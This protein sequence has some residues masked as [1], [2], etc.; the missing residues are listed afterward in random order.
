MLAPSVAIQR[1]LGGRG[2]GRFADL[3]LG[4]VWAC[5][6]WS[7]AGRP[8]LLCSGLSGAWLRASSPLVP[9][10]SDQS[11]AAHMLLMPYACGWAGLGGALRNPQK[12]EDCGPQV[13]MCANSLCPVG[14]RRALKGACAR[15]HPG[16]SMNPVSHEVT[17]RHPCLN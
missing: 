1:P 4:Q 17:H 3:T 10:P 13:T 11:P 2:G 9:E 7:C 5:T 6:G 15:D 16:G 8:F 12:T 14:G